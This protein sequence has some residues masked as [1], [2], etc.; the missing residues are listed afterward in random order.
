MLASCSPTLSIFPHVSPPRH[1][2]PTFFALVLVFRQVLFA[3]VPP[4]DMLGGWLTFAVSLVF[5][6]LLTA[7]VG[8]LASIFGCTIGL[9]DA[10]TA[11]TFVALGKVAAPQSRR[12]SYPAFTS[13]F[14]SL[15]PPLRLLWPFIPLSQAHHCLTPLL[16]RP[17]L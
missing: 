15:L 4:T 16:Q 13:L 3:A 8:D 2:I 9:P 12:T 11:I 6:G 1:P 17:R 14:L 5:I 10:I 7:I